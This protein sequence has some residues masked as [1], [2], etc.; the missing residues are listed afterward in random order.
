MNY[1]Y[2]KQILL[3]LDLLLDNLGLT[4]YQKKGNVCSKNILKN[5]LFLVLFCVILW[6]DF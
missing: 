6:N 1:L 5:N 4:N 3:V 2:K